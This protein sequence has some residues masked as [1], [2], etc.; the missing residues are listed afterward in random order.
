M[1]AV[2]FP[3]VEVNLPFL[4]LAMSRKFLSGWPGYRYALFNK[5]TR[6]ARVLGLTFSGRGERGEWGEGVSW[7][8]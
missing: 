7:R 4:E 6:P 1:K 2:T 3:S 5:F 8:P